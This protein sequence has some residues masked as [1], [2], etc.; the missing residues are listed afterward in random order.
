MLCERSQRGYILYD[1][2]I[3]NGRIHAVGKISGFQGLGGGDGV[4]LEM[5]GSPFGDDENVVKL[6]SA[7]VCPTL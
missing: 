5:W 4:Y 6:G 2:N 7:D 1:S 3:Q